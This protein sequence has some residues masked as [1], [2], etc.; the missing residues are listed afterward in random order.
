M[1]PLTD[2]PMAAVLF[3]RMS[4]GLLRSAMDHSVPEV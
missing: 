1:I 2:K 3:F 4:S